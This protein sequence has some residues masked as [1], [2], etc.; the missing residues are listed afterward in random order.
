[1][2]PKIILRRYWS[3]LNLPSAP[4]KFTTKPES[5]EVLEGSTTELHCRVS[6]LPVPAIAWTKN[7]ERLPSR[8]RHIVLPSGT[9]RILFASP[10]DQ[11]QYECQAINVIGVRLARAFLT[12]KPRGESKNKLPLNRFNLDINMKILMSAF[13]IFLVI[14]IVRR[15]LILLSNSSTVH[16]GVAHRHHCVGWTNSSN[17]L[18]CLRCSQANHNMDQ[19]QRAHYRGKQVLV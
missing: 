11:G 3:H 12:V 19:K 4:P 9:L 17:S 7:G 1:M 18:L 16:R 5:T 2:C 10:S 14:L 8:D 15:I 13:H 6:G